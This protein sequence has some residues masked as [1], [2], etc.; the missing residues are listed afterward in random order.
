MFVGWKQSALVSLQHC[1]HQDTSWDLRWLKKRGKRRGKQTNKQNK[2]E[3]KKTD[4]KSEL[5][6]LIITRLEERDIM[7]YNFNSLEQRK[8]STTHAFS[9]L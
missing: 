1:L 9:F 6:G 4:G 8:K 3:P 7:K 2:H 5:H